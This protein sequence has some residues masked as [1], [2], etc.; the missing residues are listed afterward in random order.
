MGSVAV[1]NDLITGA[2]ELLAALKS[3]QPLT[4]A[5]RAALLR[6]VDKLR[7]GL[8]GPA[9]AMNFQGTFIR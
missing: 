2:E 7:C 5:N 3:Q 1:E 8:Q 4:N 9:E 6:Q